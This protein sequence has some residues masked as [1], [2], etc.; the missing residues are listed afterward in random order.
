VL[1]VTTRN[2]LHSWRFCLPMLRAR[3]SIRQQLEQT[4]G[5]IRQ[6]TAMASPTEFFTFTVWESRRAMFHFMSSGAH[7]AFMWMFA[8]W[9]ASFWSMRWLPTAAEV[10]T[11]DGVALAGLMSDQPWRR[12]Q[13]PPLPLPEQRLIDGS[14]GRSA[15]PG[16]SGV[17]A[18]TALI[19][20]AHPGRAWA[21]RR[22]IQELGRDPRRPPILR[23]TVGVVDRHRCLALILW[24]A[25]EHQ[26]PEALPDLVGLIQQRLRATW[27]MRWAAGEYE[28]G[29]WNGMRLRQLAAARARQEQHALVS[30]RL[31]G[32]ARSSTTWERYSNGSR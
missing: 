17:V 8:R 13:P 27:T 10:G 31:N 9:S 4:P 32:Q 16:R 2:K 15:D 21:L 5:L 6:L 12:P 20:T 24:Q 3:R 22:A 14:A 26:E 19:E 11:W 30:H 1:A 7:E 29:H 23:C 18:T 28:I 25:T